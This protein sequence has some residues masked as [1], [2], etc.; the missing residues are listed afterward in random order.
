MFTSKANPALVEAR[1]DIEATPEAH[2][3][4]MLKVKIYSLTYLI[5]DHTYTWRRLDDQTLA[6]AIHARNVLTRVQRMGEA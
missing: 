4:A 2:R 6:Y 5:E 3:M 1:E